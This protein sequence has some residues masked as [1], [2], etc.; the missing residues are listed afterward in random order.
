MPRQNLLQSRARLV[1][2]LGLMLK[3]QKHREQLISCAYTFILVLE[4][5]ASNVRSTIVL[6][7]L[8]RLHLRNQ[9]ILSQP[10]A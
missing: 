6:Q 10:L 4:H 8:V 5:A 9:W 7:V 3:L 1:E 2:C